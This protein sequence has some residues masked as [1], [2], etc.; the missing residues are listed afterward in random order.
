MIKLHWINTKKQNEFT[1]DLHLKI[2]LSCN[3]S[4]NVAKQWLLK[5]DWGETIIHI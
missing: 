3:S 4:L 5:I 1:N 2:I